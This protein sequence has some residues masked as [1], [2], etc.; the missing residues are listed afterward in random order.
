MKKWLAAVLA[1]SV[2]GT[3]SG[4]A[5]L[6]AF[7]QISTNSSNQST[8]NSESDKD[9]SQDGLNFHADNNGDG[10]ANIVMQV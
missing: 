10:I 9:N 2:I 3:F 1:L 8:G 7:P 6:D 5:V 4:C